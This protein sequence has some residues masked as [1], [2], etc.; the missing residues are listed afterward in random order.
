MGTMTVGNIRY[1]TWRPL[2]KTYM[3]VL[4]KSTS[5]KMLEEVQLFKSSKISET[6]C[7]DLQVK[8]LHEKK[9]RPVSF[10]T[11]TLYVITHG[12]SLSRFLGRDHSDIPNQ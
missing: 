6:L 10:E 7:Y 4:N 5:K 8:K 2:S 3:H 12:R 1:K 11:M 9:D